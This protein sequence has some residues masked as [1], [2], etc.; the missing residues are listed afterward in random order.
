MKPREVF[1]LLQYRQLC[2]CV[3]V[4]DTVYDTCSLDREIVDSTL[5]SM[6]RRVTLM[7]PNNSTP[8]LINNI[9]TIQTCQHACWILHDNRT[10]VAEARPC[11]YQQPK[12]SSGPMFMDS[13]WRVGKHY[14]SNYGLTPVRTLNGLVRCGVLQLYLF[15]LL[16]INSHRTNK[17]T[18]H[19]AQT[20]CT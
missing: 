9:S 16:Q 12:L 14:I 18:D 8:R 15:I 11:L 4:C 1:W 2:V 6:S 7:C 13:A 10:A 19:L 3:C 17:F 20:S 5:K